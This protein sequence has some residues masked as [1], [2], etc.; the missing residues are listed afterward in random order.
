M[1]IEAVIKREVPAYGWK[2]III[3]F[4]K[5]VSFFSTV[6]CRCNILRWMYISL[7]TG[8]SSVIAI[9]QAIIIS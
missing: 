1:K 5:Y 4:K 8:I 9:E 2:G 7:S 3:Y 6:I